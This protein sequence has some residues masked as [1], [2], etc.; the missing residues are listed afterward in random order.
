MKK[1]I[2]EYKLYIL[3]GVINI[4]LGIALTSGL[5][6]TAG[7]LGRVFVAIGGLLF[8]IGMGKKKQREE[9]HLK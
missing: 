1:R 9:N 2:E 4:S 5:K 3:A 7:S 6:E 8:I